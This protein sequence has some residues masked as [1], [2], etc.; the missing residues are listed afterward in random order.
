MAE[1]TTRGTIPEDHRLPPAAPAGEPRGRGALPT[2]DHR[3]PPERPRTAARSKAPGAGS[4]PDGLRREIEAT[5]ARMSRT[6][7][8]IEGTLVRQ[9]EEVVAR[10]TL[11]DLRHRI[12]TSPLR[13]LMIAFAA[14]YVVAAIRD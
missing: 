1:T 7:D 10:V 13:P 2:G 8:E 5:R 9:K 6:L 14:G 4:D 3:R 12:A 11:R